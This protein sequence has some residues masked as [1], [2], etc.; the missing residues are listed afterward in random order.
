MTLIVRN[1]VAAKM[2]VGTI[3]PRV[4]RFLRVSNV[5]VVHVDEGFIF[6]YGENRP[7]VLVEGCRAAARSRSKSLTSILARRCRIS[8]R[9][10]I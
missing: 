4:L 8:L 9:N 5:H 1:T 10:M 2:R 6:I 7:D 3:G